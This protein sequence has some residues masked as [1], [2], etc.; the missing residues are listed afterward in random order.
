MSDETYVPFH[1]IAD[2]A[3]FHKVSSLID[4]VRDTSAPGAAVAD[5]AGLSMLIKTYN[6]VRGELDGALV[7]DAAADALALC[8][9]LADDASQSTV[10]VA[11]TLLA[12][13]CDVHLNTPGFVT[14]MKVNGQQMAAAWSSDEPAQPPALTGD[15]AVGSYL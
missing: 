1:T 12:R 8:D 7:A 9:Q 5:P 14:A 4:V 15:P 13:V 6:A 3:L 2:R 11:A 10:H